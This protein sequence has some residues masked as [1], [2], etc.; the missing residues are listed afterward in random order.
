MLKNTPITL[1]YY[2]ETYSLNSTCRPCLDMIP[3]IRTPKLNKDQTGPRHG[4]ASMPAAI[5][6]RE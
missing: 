5:I 4:Q 6:P 1:A 3:C 2:H